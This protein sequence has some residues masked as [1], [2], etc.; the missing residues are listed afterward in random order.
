MHYLWQNNFNLLTQKSRY[1]KKT[2][3]N[4]LIGNLWLINKLKNDVTYTTDN[5]QNKINYHNHITK[6][7]T[8]EN[9]K[10]TTIENLPATSNV[11]LK[12]Q[13]K[14]VKNISSQTTNVK[15]KESSIQIFTSWTELSHS[16][17]S[18]ENCTLCNGRTNTVLER[19]SG[20]AK[21]MFIGEGPGEHE[22]LQG[23]PFVGAS[24]QLLDKM[25]KAMQ[26][27]PDTDVYI[28]NVIKCRPPHNRNPT[29]VE[30]E[31][32][33][34]Y[35]FSQIEL[36]APNII[37]TLGRFAAQTI[38][39]TETAIGKLRNT[40]HIYNKIPVIVTYHPS[41]LLRTPSAKKEAWSDL[42]LAIKTFQ[43]NLNKN[44]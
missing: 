29:K 19:G 14:S 8:L 25:I 16:V 42:Q 15:E 24:G 6:L 22:D 3:Q 38:L 1:M 35:L 33:S 10:L 11:E 4:L 40:I 7:S 17:I 44:L 2:V 27:N 21:W 28:A 23:K 9:S 43:Q 32:C 26:L 39:N 5:T 41:Y 31:A 30:I 13:Q 34:N 37:I 12:I 20:A 36:L 18:C